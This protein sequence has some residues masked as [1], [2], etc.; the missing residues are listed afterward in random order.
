[1]VKERWLIKF[2]IWNKLDYFEGRQQFI[3]SEIREN[4]TTVML[5]FLFIY[6]IAILLKNNI[7]LF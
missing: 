2:K 3:S 7:Q 5:R 6:N 1:M 4:I